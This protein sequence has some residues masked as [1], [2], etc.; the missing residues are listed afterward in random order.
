MLR[1]LKPCSPPSRRALALAA[2]LGLAAGAWGCGER[3]AAEETPVSSAADVAVRVPY[4]LY[5]HPGPWWR[6]N[7]TQDDFDRDIW[8]CRTESK[9]ARNEASSE[10]RKDVAYRTF[11][12]CMGDLAWHRGHPPHDASRSQDSVESD[13]SDETSRAAAL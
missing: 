9:R 8:E 1:S 11:V 7:A 6:D 5:G 2:V 3:P 10:N 12:D 13:P 4:E